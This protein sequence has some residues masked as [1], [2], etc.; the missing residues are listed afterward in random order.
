MLTLAV[1]VMFCQDTPSRVHE[2]VSA[3]RGHWGIVA[4]RVDNGE[5]IVDRCANCFFTPASI[6]KL[7]S[8]VFAFER[9]GGSHRFPTEVRQQGRDL[10]LTGGGDPSLSGRPYPYREGHG[11]GPAMSALEMLASAVAARGIREAHDVV[12]DDTLWA[13]R[14]APDGWSHDD[15]TWDFGAPL[16]ALSF[17]ESSIQL[18]MMPGPR[19]GDLA[20]VSLSPAVEYF[21]IDNR[22]ETT[23][24]G[25]RQIR[26]TRMPSARQLLITGSIP[27]N[28][29]GR[30]EILA[31]DDPALFAAAAF[32]EALIRQG[33]TVTGEIRALH[34]GSGDGAAARARGELVAQRMS[35]PLAQLAQVVNKVSQNLHAEMLLEAS[36]GV[37]ALE[38][39]LE[40]TLQV[41]RTEFRFVDGSG[42][43]RL[44]MITPR[45]LS[46]VLLHMKDHRDFLDT[47]PVGGV[48]GSLRFR[49]TRPHLKVQAKTGGMTG[50]QTLAGYVDSKSNGRVAFVIMVNNDNSPG[51]V[52]RAAIDRVVAVLAD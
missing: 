1:L 34:R 47:L 24:N 51:A 44:D 37:E 14:P 15:L 39:F 38:G 21:S 32:R 46:R 43:S 27:W 17:A 20:R 18:T 42:L 28:D 3:H 2:I 29:R 10:Y 22:L 4:V 50:V 48:D 6:T 11:T 16:S 41:P 52:T 26:I 8:T 7:V 40:E 49:F 19:V 23:A 36:G 35:P 25:A 30:S 33:V 13:W 5:T 31:V 45:A 12:G 9:L